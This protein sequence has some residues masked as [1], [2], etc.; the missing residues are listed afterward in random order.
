MRRLYKCGYGKIWNIC[1]KHARNHE[2]YGVTK[3]KIGANKVKIIA[4]SFLRFIIMVFFLGGIYVS[5][6]GNPNANNGAFTAMVLLGFAFAV[7][8]LRHLNDVLVLCSNKI[9]LKKR[10]LFFSTPEEIKWL[11]KRTYFVGTRLK[12]C[13]ETKDTGWKEILFPYNEID[14]T[15]IKDPHEEFIKFYMNTIQGETKHV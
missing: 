3:M 9:V 2:L 5:G 12:C 14:V 4:V 10:E 11:H 6:I 7:S 15:Y 8:P 13:R 1:G